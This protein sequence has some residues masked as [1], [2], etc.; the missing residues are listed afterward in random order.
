MI[1]GVISS[2]LHHHRAMVHWV[3]TNCFSKGPVFVDIELS[4][5]CNLRCRM[6][7][8]HGA[9]GVGDRYPNS[10]ITT[11]EVLELINQLAAY[12]PTLYFGGG[13][14]FL[15]EDFLEILSH[16]HSL[17]LSTAFTTNGTLLDRE[18]IER[19]VALEVHAITFSIDGPEA[20]NDKLRGEGHFK[21]AI[22]S[23]QSL[24]ESKT[25]KNLQKPSI[26][27]NI[28]VNPTVV[29][30]LKETVETI[31]DR[32]GNQID[33]LRIHHLWFIT[34]KELQAHKE[35]VHDA[36][37]VWAPGAESH[38]FPLR[39]FDSALLADEIAPLK[40]A[41][42]IRFFPDMQGKEIRDYYSDGYRL[43][44]R[45]LAPF[46]AAVVKPNGDVK[47]CPDEWID[48]YVLGNVRRDRFE[49]IWNHAKAKHFRSVIFRR[50][51]FPA[52]KRCSW[53]HCY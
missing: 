49:A 18:K 45:C 42:N 38:C 46:H 41:G 25:R 13:E 44:K 19:I 7:W 51:S 24:L 32:I 52:C 22:S 11:G 34:P 8:F 30:H 15:R 6:C 23:I 1:R 2:L 20:L 4:N 28:T 53:M 16:A 12:R 50:K 33:F 5:R 31:R 27:V 9:R 37:E 29:G 17:G 39:R 48:D 21:K 36:L 26:A 10:E 40:N 35:A 3:R 47:F 14:P 43:P